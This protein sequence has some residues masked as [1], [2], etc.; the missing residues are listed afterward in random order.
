MN[1]FDLVRNTQNIILANNK[2]GESVFRYYRH[3]CNTMFGSKTEWLF[4]Y[5]W[6]VRHNNT[7]CCLEYI[8][9]LFR[10]ADKYR[11]FGPI[12]KI[13]GASLFPYNF[14]GYVD[15]YNRG[16]ELGFSKLES[17]V[18]SNPAYYQ[19][20]VF[21]EII[22]FPHGQSLTPYTIYDN[23]DG[24][25]APILLANG[26]WGS[27]V[28]VSPDLSEVGILNREVVISPGLL[29][30][31]KLI[32]RYFCAWCIVLDSYVL[33]ESMFQEYLQTIGL[34]Y[35]ESENKKKQPT[36]LFT[37]YLIHPNKPKLIEEL[38]GRSRGGKGKQIAIM[39]LALKKCGMINFADGE[40]SKLYDSMRGIF[41]SIGVNSGIDDYISP[42]ESKNQNNRKP[43]LKDSEIEVYS[44]FLKKI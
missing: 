10:N 27:E 16:F 24:L 9:R 39:L 23:R 42:Y 11:L 8:V 5:Y 29:E 13:N 14:R 2:D 34:I 15:G 26:E 32:G 12:S 19:P 6:S 3:L 31:G 36:P 21:S 4:T 1:T 18:K 38:L 22:S 37:S 44:N 30:F 28:L 17:Q 40:R 43:L 7:F 20:V 41:G 33:Y 25:T 35:Q